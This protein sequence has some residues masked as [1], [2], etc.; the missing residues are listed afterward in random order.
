M[1]RPARPTAAASGA[2]IRR[3]RFS[4]RVLPSG[5]KM[6]AAAS[7]ARTCSIGHS[8]EFAPS[9]VAF[10]AFQISGSAHI[11]PGTAS[12]RCAQGSVGGLF[13]S[14]RP[15][16]A[17]KANRRTDAGHSAA[18]SAASEAPTELPARSAPAS[19]DLIE[20]LPHRE[21]PVQMRVQHAYG[22]GRR[23]ENPAATARSPCAPSPV[24]PGTA[25]SAAGRRIRRENRASGRCPCARCASESR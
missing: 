10:I 1:I 12:P 5:Q 8:I 9:G 6:R 21:Q 24:R 14:N 4:I 17:I 3:R 16:G 11:R 18:T 2:L 15:N 19:P 25:S 20:D 22:R 23:R 7:L 13:S